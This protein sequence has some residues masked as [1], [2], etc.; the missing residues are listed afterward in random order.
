MNSHYLEGDIVKYILVPDMLKLAARYLYAYMTQCE[1][2]QQPFPGGFS[3][4][5]PCI[6]EMHGSEIEVLLSS[7]FLF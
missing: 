2:V 7:F 4:M 3:V 5:C 6:C 1:P